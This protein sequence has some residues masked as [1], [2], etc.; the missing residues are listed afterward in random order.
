[1]RPVDPIEFTHGCATNTIGSARLYGLIRRSRGGLRLSGSLRELQTIRASAK[2]F[3]TAD[4]YI[5]CYL[6]GALEDISDERFLDDL[7]EELSHLRQAF[8]QWS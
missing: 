6:E 7:Y 4:A 1:M 2:R 5:T 8:D 3:V